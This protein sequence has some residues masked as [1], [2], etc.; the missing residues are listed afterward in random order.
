MKRRS[1]R[2]A[3]DGADADQNVFGGG[4]CIFHEHVEI[5]VLV[6]NARIHQFELRIFARS[7]TILREELFIGKGGLWILVKALEVGTRGGRVKIK[8]IF[9][10]VFAVIAFFIGQAEKAFFQNGVAFIPQRQSEADA[11]MAVAESGDSVLTPTIDARAR[12]VVRKISPSVAVGAVILAYR[13]PLALGK[14]RPPPFPMHFALLRFLD[15]LL[16]ALHQRF[17]EKKG[18]PS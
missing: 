9:F 10:D 16:F 15:S 5:T 11:L 1:L 4:F 3:V 18:R 6:K 2:A 17:L 8:I 14:I 12:M 7:L 13:S